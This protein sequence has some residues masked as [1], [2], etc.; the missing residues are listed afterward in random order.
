MPNTTNNAT[1]SPAV[2]APAAATAVIPE[3][4][5]AHTM[6]AE[7]VELL[8]D[9]LPARPAAEL[10]KVGIRTYWQL[11]KQVWFYAGTYRWYIP[12][13]YALYIPAVGFTLLQPYAFGEALNALQAHGPGYLRDV[14]Y[15]LSIFTCTILAM[16]IFHGPGRVLER[17]VGYRV[18]ESFTNTAY[19]KLTELPVTWHQEHHS[20]DSINRIGVAAGALRGFTEEQFVY[21]QVSLRMVGTVAIMTWIEPVI[22]LFT[23]VALAGCFWMTVWFDRRM[24]KLNHQ[25]NELGHKYYATFM[26]FVTNMATLRILRLGTQSRASVSRAISNT[27][28]PFIESA[29]L[30]EWK[31]FAFS[32][33]I[34]V[35]QSLMI[36]GYIVWQLNTIGV[37]AIGTLAALVRYQQELSGTIT[38]MADKL[39]GLLNGGINVAAANK[40]F[41]EHDNLVES[42]DNLPNLDNWQSLTL[43]HVSFTH[44]PR[45]GADEAA[46]KP[47]L[48]DITLTVKRGEKIAL[49]G[50]SGGGKSTLLGI[51][52]GIYPPSAGTLLMD[53]QALPLQALYNQTTLIPQDPEMFENSV[54]FNITLGLPAEPFALEEAM[55]LSAFDVV[56]ETLPQGLRTLINEKGV[57]MSGGQKQ[58]LALARGL[59]AAR[60]S[61]VVLMDEPTSSLDLATEQTVY[62]ETFASWGDKTV[63]ATLHRL[64]LLPLFDRIIFMDRGRITADGPSAQL[65]EQPGPVR[66]LYHSN[67]QKGELSVD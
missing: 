62:R 29:K 1:A 35:T 32:M 2:A 58:R 66:T 38:T 45:L 49:I 59:Y 25:S 20:G 47:G 54:R 17:I 44:K 34:T 56:L 5:T 28:P 41:E 50:T 18:W 37:V 19:R 42:R 46:A 30:N 9:E 40:L 31:W 64:H 22:G 48:S 15:W 60:H 33:I 6:N 61:S 14:I 43:E 53:G 36:V 57:N 24:V 11:L 55:R 63:F 67:L 16:W 10:P 39:N 8:P 26:D 51:I 12:A 27:Y 21:L 3:P 23:L 4:S 52:R 7:S 65:L 13:F